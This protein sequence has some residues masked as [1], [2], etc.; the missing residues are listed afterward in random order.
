MKIKT[1]AKIF[2]DD[3][4]F[5]TNKTNRNRTIENKHKNKKIISFKKFELKQGNLFHKYIYNINFILFGFILLIL[6]KKL[7]MIEHY[8]SLKVSRTGYQQILSNEYNG[9]KPCAIYIE[10]DIQVMRE[11]KVEVKDIGKEIILKWENKLTDFT[12]MFSN[13]I[14]ITAVKLYNIFESRSNS[15]YM[16]YNCKSLESFSYYRNDGIKPEITDTISL[17][18]NCISLRSFSFDQFNMNNNN[19]NRY[20]S[21][22]FYNCQS[23]NNLIYTY[24]YYVRDIRGLFYNCS[25]L[26]EIKL[27]YFYTSSSSKANSSYLFYNCILLEKVSFQNYFYTNAMESMFYNCQKLIS[28]NLTPIRTDNSINISRLFYNCSQLSSVKGDFHNFYISDTREMFF[29]CTSFKHY[30]DNNNVKQNY[31]I[32][33]LQHNNQNI[34]VNM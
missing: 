29:N 15:S 20:M 30:Y 34:N 28:I 10:N 4:V 31:I 11:R 5:L 21:Y 2:N 18:Y 24:I 6:P 23:L 16:F 22:M 32:M 14:S 25:K 17:F 33:Y 3:F 19:Y 26:T 8:I 1:K 9:P 13:L 12:Y 7:L 27:E